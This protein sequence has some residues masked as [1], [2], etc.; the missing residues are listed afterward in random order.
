MILK[1]FKRDETFVAL[2]DKVIYFKAEGHYRGILRPRLQDP[3][4]LRPFADG[5]EAERDG[6]H[7]QSVRESGT[8]LYREHKESGVC[9]HTEG[10]HNAARQRQ[11]LPDRA[12][13]EKLH[14]EPHQ[15]HEDPE[16]IRRAGKRHCQWGGG[17]FNS[18]T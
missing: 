7:E 4:A 5:T 8:E 9:E 15:G 13:A 11:Q 18:Q 10:V 2:L 6:G 12:R 3:P 16:R 1:L 17:I 14:Q